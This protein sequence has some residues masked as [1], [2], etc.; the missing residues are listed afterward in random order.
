MER[1]WEWTDFGQIFYKFF[2]SNIKY[3]L[4]N[5]I[6]F[7]VGNG[8]MTIKQKRWIITLI[9]KNTKNWLYLKKTGD[10]NSFWSLIIKCLLNY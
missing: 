7:A 8:E 6:K 4:I 3:L 9:P 5:S 2:W 10:L 1:V